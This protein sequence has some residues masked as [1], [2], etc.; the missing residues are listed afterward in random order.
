MSLVFKKRYFLLLN[1]IAVIVDPLFF[2]IPVMNDEKKC[3]EFDQTLVITSTVLR[4]VFDFFK[5]I[6]VIYVLLLELRKKGF[7]DWLAG[8]YLEIMVIFPIP[9]VRQISKI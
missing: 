5:M 7:R 1:V 3:I 9:Q 2:Y 8:C 6:H 4:S